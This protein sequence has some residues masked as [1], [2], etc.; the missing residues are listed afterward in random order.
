MTLSRTIFNQLWVVRVEISTLDRLVFWWIL[1][2]LIDD[3]SDKLFSELGV[4]LYP[5]PQ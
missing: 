5:Y 3:R 1:P 2:F 4:E